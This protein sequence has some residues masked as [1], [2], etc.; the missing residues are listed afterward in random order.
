MKTMDDGAAAM[1]RPRTGH[2]SSTGLD[3][4]P[5]HAQALVTGLLPARDAQ[6]HSVLLRLLEIGFVPGET[7]RVVARGGLGGDPIA[8]RVGQ[9][10]FALRHKEASMVQV[11]PTVQ[12]AP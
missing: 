11:A 4:L 3:A 10:T 8:V 5:L 9:V 6:E 12:E 2:S 1:L 7:V